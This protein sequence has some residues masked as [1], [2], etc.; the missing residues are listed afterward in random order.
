MFHCAPATV[1][2]GNPAPLPRRRRGRGRREPGRHRPRR[3][4]ASASSLW[5]AGAP[6][7]EFGQGRQRVV[8]N[9][10]PHRRVPRA[11]LGAPPSEPLAHAGQLPTREAAVADGQVERRI[12]TD[13][14][15]LIVKEARLQVGAEVPAVGAVAVEEPLPEPVHGHVVIARHGQKGNSQAFEKPAR[16]PELTL[17]WRAGSGRPIRRPGRAGAPLTSAS[18][19]AAAGS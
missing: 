15:H 12:E 1:A 4:A 14:L 18:T 9:R 5:R 17:P 11:G 19:P 10:D 8:G 3:N 16:L 13:D 6:A 2:A 7:H